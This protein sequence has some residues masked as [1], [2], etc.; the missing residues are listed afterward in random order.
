MVY[1]VTCDYFDVGGLQGGPMTSDDAVNM[2]D[3]TLSRLDDATRNCVEFMKL[4]VP[5]IFDV[6]SVYTVQR[7]QNLLLIGFTLGGNYS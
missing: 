6:K 7:N 5:K 1:D 2:D 3:E 4:F